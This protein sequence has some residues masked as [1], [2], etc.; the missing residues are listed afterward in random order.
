[1]TASRTQSL[2]QTNQH[3]FTLIELM[4]GAV[5]GML[6]VL[7]ISQVLIQSESTRRNA[8]SGGDAEVN[9]SLSMF[10]MQ[11]DIQM[12]GYG[13]ASNQDALGCKVKNKHGTDPNPAS[14]TAPNEFT[15]APVTIKNATV[16]GA[17]D[18]I[19]ILQGNTSSTSIPTK[20]TQDN[21][22]D[23]A[24]NIPG[25][26]TVSASIGFQAGDQIVAVPEIWD[27]SNAAQWCTLFAITNSSVSADTKLTSDNIP[28][29]P[30]DEWNKSDIAPAGGYPS[31]SYLL[32]L[33][34]PIFKTYSVSNTYNLQVTERASASGITS[35]QDLYQQI[36]NLQALYGM[37]TNSDGTV[38]K[39]T[40]VTPTN[41]AEWKQ[42]IT[43]RVALVARS[44]QYER[45][46]VTTEEPQWNLGKAASIEG[47]T[48]F[49][50]GTNSKCVTLKLET[51]PEWQHYRYKVYST[52]IPLRNVLW[53]S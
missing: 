6:T 11:R 15:L 25:R 13:L 52:T 2:R 36:V 10:T 49:D 20:I 9:G 42:V 44:N 30:S 8:A 31:G 50:C 23:I 29:S 45:E 32:N 43:V 7:V 24:K 33:G 19:T 18:E 51:L 28:H 21:P 16:D 27:P 35:T 5:L 26:F 53:N 12:A 34:Q 41:N 37:D 47:E 17:S 4:V 39:Y 46:P 22:P 40:N 14:P 38:D 1:M 3:G 48:T